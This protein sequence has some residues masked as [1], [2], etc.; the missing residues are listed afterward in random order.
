MAIAEHLADWRAYLTAKGGTAKHVGH[1]R[2]AV[3]R[4]VSTMKAETPADLTPAKVQ[5]AIAGLKDN[6][7]SLRTC[8]HAMRAVKGFTRRAM[9]NGRLA[10]DPLA[11]LTGFNTATDR[12]HERRPLIADELATLLKVTEAAPA[13]RGISGADRAMTYRVAVGTGFRL[14]ELA[15]LTPGSFDLDA[16]PPAVTI[17]AAY[18]RHRRDDRQ[19]IRADLAEL[20][21][22]YLT[23]KPSDAPALCIPDRAAHM[24][25]AH[26]R[27]ARA[28]WI[29]DTPQP[30]ERRQRRQAGFL[31]HADADGRVVDFHALRVT[32]ITMIVKGGA[33]VKVAQELARHSDPRLTMNTY[34]RLG[35]HDLTGALDALPD[36]T[37]ANSEPHTMRA[38]GTDNQRADAGEFDHQQYR[39]QRAHET[40]RTSAKR[41]DEHKRGSRAADERKPLVFP[42]KNRTVQRGAVV[43]ENA[44][45]W[46][47]TINPLIKSLFSGMSTH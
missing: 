39:Q 9:R 5:G 10:S 41:C 17:R 7:L 33:S 27:R 4:L 18:S 24:L 37:P 35:V 32:Y 20:L 30:A 34:T 40:G 45:R 36:A 28:R 6:G 42:I 11:W 44:P 29:K 46:T 31:T 15:S 21:R 38:T 3:D 12:R 14:S 22:G 19:P 23:N 26:M 8:N 2:G 1:V 16:N 25:K 47:R 43:S 13:W